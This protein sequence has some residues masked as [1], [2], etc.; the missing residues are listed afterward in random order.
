M[1][2]LQTLKKHESHVFGWDDGGS[3]F[4]DFLFISMKMDKLVRS[5]SEPTFTSAD[6]DGYLD[7]LKLL[8]GRICLL[9]AISPRQVLVK[10]SFSLPH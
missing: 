2:M 8:A 7:G 1:S 9:P 5:Q 3:V 10:N 4:L 6:L